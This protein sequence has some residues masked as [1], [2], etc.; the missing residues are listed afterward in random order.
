MIGFPIRLAIAFLIIVLA[1]PPL[2]ELAG[3]FRDDINISSA[4]SEANRI[5]DTLSSVYYAGDGNTAYIDIHVPDGY[6]ICIGGLDDR[7]YTL[8]V[9]YGDEIEDI[10]Y[11]EHPAVK[12]TGNQ[13]C[14]SGN[15]GLE[16][17]CVGNCVEV[18]PI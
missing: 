10:V 12:I 6:T 15:S 16:I 18:R 11:L 13:V 17:T 2:M 9:L 7:A 5:R 3:D 4:N 14:V 8:S 1:V